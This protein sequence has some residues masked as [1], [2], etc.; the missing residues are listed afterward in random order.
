MNTFETVFHINIFW[1]SFVWFCVSKILGFDFCCWN[2]VGYRLRNNASHVLYVFLKDNIMLKW[3]FVVKCDRIVLGKIW[4]I[5]DIQNHRFCHKSSKS[6][7]L[8][9][10][11]RLPTCDQFWPKWP[12]LPFRRNCQK[13]AD[14]ASEWN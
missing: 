13:L 9:K 7:T 12:I 14:N 5:L 1:K 6:P 10:Q 8:T 4:A 2:E 3:V 11:A